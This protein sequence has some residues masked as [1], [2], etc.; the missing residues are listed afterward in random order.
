MIPAL[1]ALKLLT[2]PRWVE[3]APQAFMRVKPLSDVGFQQAWWRYNFSLQYESPLLLSQPRPP[4]QQR[5]L[6]RLLA[7]Y[8]LQGWR[9]VMVDGQTVL[10]SRRAARRLLSRY[11]YFLQQV[12]AASARVD[13]LNRRNEATLLKSLATETAWGNFAPWVK[14]IKGF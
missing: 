1:S 5:Q 6:A 14:K 7:R 10:F 2:A 12:V 8:I 11:P 9:G 4:N 3:F 13:A